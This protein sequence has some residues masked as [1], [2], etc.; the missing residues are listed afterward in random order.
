MR[1]GLSG[2][3]RIGR[4]LIRQLFSTTDRQVTCALINTTTSPSILAHL[5]KYDSIHGFWD[6]EVIGEDGYL[7]INGNRIPLVSERSPDLIPWED[8]QVELA[9]DATGKFNHRIGAEKHLLAGAKKVLITAPGSQM[10]VTIVMGVNEDAYDPHL[11]RIIS[12][13]SCTTN[14]LAPILRLLDDAFQ[15]KE[16]WMT[17]VHAFTSDQKHVDNPHPDLRR[18][19]ACT[20]SIIPTTTGVSKALANVLPHLAP[21]IQGVSIRVP[22]Q[23]VSLLDLQVNLG[24]DVTGEDIKN[25]IL[26]A[27][28]GTL[29]KVVAYNELPLVSVDYIGNPHSAVIDGLSILT[30]GNQVKL[31]AWY[32]NEWAYASRIQEFVVHM[33]QIHRMMKARAI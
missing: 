14:C 7:L 30:R 6:A 17:T 4:L 27:I 25:A 20:N 10:D 9:I 15:V 13:A 8:Y 18:A 31:L 3:G 28:R 33:V 16:G 11:H 29:G 1:I 2:T 26:Q 5:L 32:D 12:T 23:N 21:V 24:Q 22:T 19:R